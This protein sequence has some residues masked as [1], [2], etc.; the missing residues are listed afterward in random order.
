MVTLQSGTM[1]DQNVTSLQPSP[2][3]RTFTTSTSWSS[4][5]H[6]VLELMEIKAN[7]DIHKRFVD[8]RFTD[9]FMLL[10]LSDQENQGLTYDKLDDD[11]NIV[12]TNKSLPMYCRSLLLL[13]TNFF[14]KLKQDSGRRLTEEDILDTTRAEY[15]EFWANT[16]SMQDVPLVSHPTQSGADAPLTR[17]QVMRLKATNFEKSIKRDK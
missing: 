15:K 1:T 16:N 2:I 11:G 14:K 7:S 17:D 12:T 8:N 3:A 4:F 10:G 13:L 6:V 9:A 5:D